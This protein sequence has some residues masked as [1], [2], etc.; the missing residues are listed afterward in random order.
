MI[1]FLK[2]EDI[3]AVQWDATIHKSQYPTIFCTYRMLDI[4][5][6]DA[7]WNALVMD[8]Y[9]YVMPL[10]ERSRLGIHYVYPPFFVSQ[11]GI[12]SEKP[13][14]AQVTSDFFN[15][16]PAADKH[17]DFMFNSSNNIDFIDN[18][19]ISL[20]TYQMQ[21]GKPYAEIRAGFSQN[22]RRNIKA[23]QN[24]GLV[25]QCDKEAV[26]SIVNLFRE[27]KGKSREVHFKERDYEILTHAAA[28]L[29]ELGCIEPLVVRDRDGN[30]LAGAL[31]VRDFNTYRFWFSGRD[32]R[33]ADRKAMF[34]LLDNFI[35][36]HADTPAILD[37]NGSM[38]E[39]IAR[40][41]KGFG[42]QP[43]PIKMLSYSRQV[44]WDLLLK[45]YRLIRK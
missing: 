28:A 40:L 9:Q 36:E 22:T 45:L 31:M 13:V 15:A 39:N 32:E 16:L 18:Y 11:M 3:D 4:L 19:T 20:V 29:G 8:D 41:Y 42:G 26:G 1:R 44:Y 35:R 5:V 23:A 7:T 25:M 12:F 43:V 10:P 37:F 34:F 21:L 14:S 24:H 17:V 6:G 30:L 33:F 27:N 38:N 2:H